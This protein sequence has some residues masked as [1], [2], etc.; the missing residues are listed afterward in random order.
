MYDILGFLLTKWKLERKY[1]CVYR[2]IYIKGQLYYSVSSNK[3][4]YVVCSNI[5]FILWTILR[6]NII[7]FNLISI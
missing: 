7:N 5:N 1:N 4:N 3:T 2:Y 6:V